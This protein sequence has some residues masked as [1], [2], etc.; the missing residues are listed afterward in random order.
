MEL[1]G[2]GGIQLE[3]GMADLQAQQE[4]AAASPAGMGCDGREPPG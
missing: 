4:E 3:K 2:E 1:N